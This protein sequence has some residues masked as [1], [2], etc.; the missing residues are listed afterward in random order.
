[1]IKTHL[2]AYNSILVF[3][4]W[5]SSA[6]SYTPLLIKF[7][8]GV[9]FVCACMDVLQMSVSMILVMLN[10]GNDSVLVWTVKLCVD[11]SA[12]TAV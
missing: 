6:L 4:F 7:F 3:G 2:T 11:G 10:G 8:F 12:Q 5:V 9:Y 1:M